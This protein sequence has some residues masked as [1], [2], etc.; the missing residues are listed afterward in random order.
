LKHIR[1]LDRRHITSQWT[2]FLEIALRLRRYYCYDLTDI[3]R[4]R[5]YVLAPCSPPRDPLS[6]TSFSL[7]VSNANDRKRKRFRPGRNDGKR[8]DCGGWVER[9]GW[10]H[11]NTRYT[12]KQLR[13]PGSRPGRFLFLS[14][15]FFFTSIFQK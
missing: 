10:Q 12:R 3:G 9:A 1:A 5:T 13:V 7:D 4:F 14:S 11:C 6:R 15:H 8:S 2:R